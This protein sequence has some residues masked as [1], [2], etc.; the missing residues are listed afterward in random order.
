MEKIISED[1]SP[2]NIKKIK[3]ESS[4]FIPLSESEIKSFMKDESKNI[5]TISEQFEINPKNIF[6]Y[7][8]R[9]NLV[10]LR[11]HE[12]SDVLAVYLEDYIAYD[13]DNYLANI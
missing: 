4:Y 13:L 10:Y 8:K 1:Y 5:K 11:E 2:F 6:G 9:S 3:S 12:D 7:D